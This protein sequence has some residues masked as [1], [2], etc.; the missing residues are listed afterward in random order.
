MNEFNDF[1]IFL[2]P[3]YNLVQ[4]VKTIQ[5]IP[6]MIYK[7]LSEPVGWCNATYLVTLDV[8]VLTSDGPITGWMLEYQLAMDQSQA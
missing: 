3:Y 8:G 6:N 1:S 2:H 5:M 7:Q 4:L